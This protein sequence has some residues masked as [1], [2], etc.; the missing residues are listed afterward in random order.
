MIA[1]GGGSGLAPHHHGRRRGGCR[2]RRRSGALASDTAPDT[3]PSRVFILDKIT[4]TVIGQIRKHV[5]P[6]DSYA[7]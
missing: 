1:R 7:T 6:S 4:C 3:A 5:L 2:A